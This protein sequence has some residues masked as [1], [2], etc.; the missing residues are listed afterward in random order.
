MATSRNL[1][2]LAHRILAEHGSFLA[3]VKRIQVGFLP[4]RNI[5]EAQEQLTMLQHIVA[6]MEM[7]L[8]G[9]ST[10]QQ[11]TNHQILK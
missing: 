3:A 4:E 6:E 9:H 2:T 10:N 8:K 7:S 11:P 5:K 1:S